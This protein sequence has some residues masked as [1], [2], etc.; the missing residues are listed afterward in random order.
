MGLGLTRRV[1]RRRYSTARGWW[2]V[3]PLGFLGA[4]RF[5]ATPGRALD[6][7]PA[8]AAH[9]LAR[10]RSRHGPPGLGAGPRVRQQRH[11][12]DTIDHFRID[13]RLGDTDDLA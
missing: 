8:P 3:Y 2:H 9:P 5:A 7:T 6:P 10:L 4:E 13:P 1:A 11:G 12:Y